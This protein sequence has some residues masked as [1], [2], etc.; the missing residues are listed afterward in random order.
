M[1]SFNLWREG[2]G[3]M[4]W[5]AVSTGGLHIITNCAQLCRLLWLLFMPRMKLT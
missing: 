4:K 5:P 3:L 2:G 1:L